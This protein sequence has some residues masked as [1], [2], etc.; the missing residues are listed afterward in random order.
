VVDTGL[1]VC[2][3]V[4]VTFAD[5]HAVN[6]PVNKAIANKINPAFFNKTITP[7]K[8]STPRFCLGEG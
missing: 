4:V 3:G 5:E 1:D 8:K 6:N 2:A 7:L